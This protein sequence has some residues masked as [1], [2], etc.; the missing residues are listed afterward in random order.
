MLSH[1]PLPRISNWKDPSLLAH[2]L[3]RAFRLGLPGLRQM[4][5]SIAKAPLETLH[6]AYGHVQRAF[7]TDATLRLASTFIA[8][9]REWQPTVSG[10]ALTTQKGSVLKAQQNPKLKAQQNTKLKAQQN[11]KLKAQQ[12][13]KLKAQQN[14]PQKSQ[15]AR[16]TAEPYRSTAE[17]H[18]SN[19]LSPMDFLQQ[20]GPYLSFLKAA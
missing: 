7:G 1:R 14:S 3:A 15:Q 13:T 4:R 5:S 11:T 10:S 18:L 9:V 12:N 17:E 20:P 2:E 16:K 19:Q 8:L 6:W